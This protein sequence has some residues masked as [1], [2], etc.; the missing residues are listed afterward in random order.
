MPPRYGVLWRKYIPEM[1]KRSL[2]E[3]TDTIDWN[4]LRTVLAVARAGT[5]AGAARELGLRH[6]TVFRRIEQAEARLGARLF[7]RSR[8][9]WSANAHGEAMARAAAEMETAALGAE[10]AVSGA[11][12]RLE[13]VIRLAT[14]ELLA[15]FLLPPVLAR[16]LAAHPGIEV[17]AD[18]SN[19]N[20]DLTRREADLALRAT[21]QPPQTLVG[22]QLA[23]MG[24]A[25]YASRALLGR[26]RTPPDLR[27]LP[28]IGFDERIAHFPV[29]RWFARTLPEVQPRLRLDS[30]SAMLHAAAAGAGAVV[31]PTFAGAQERSLLRITPMIEGVDV[32]LW[33]LSHPDVRGNARVRAMGTFLAEA[34]PAELER[35]SAA[36]ATCEPFAACPKAPRRRQAAAPST[37]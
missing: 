4:E 5:L 3:R 10:R 9:G 18:V 33:L 30:M 21:P 31:L 23:S 19:R 28:W 36:G 37:D 34:L 20:V 26:R 1:S 8:T 13:G 12:A 22:R 25:V 16:F 24:Y 14:S 35:L 32:G 15:G 2:Q 11:D 29:A 17:E 7:E 6:S 27:A